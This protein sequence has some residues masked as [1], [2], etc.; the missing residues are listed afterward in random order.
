MSFADII[1]LFAVSSVLGVIVETVFVY[2]VRGRLESRRGMV[3]GPFNQVY[4]LE[5]FC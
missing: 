3:Y 5:P 2:L 4:G 1:L